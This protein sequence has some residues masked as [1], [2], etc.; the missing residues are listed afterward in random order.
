VGVQPG[1][2]L[3]PAVQRVRGDDDV[4][5]V[6]QGGQGGGERG[7]LVALGHRGLG[8]HQPAGVVID[9]EHL[10]LC[11][12]G[13]T[14][15]AQRLAVG[16]QHHSTLGGRA[17]GRVSLREG[18]GAAAEHPA[19]QRRLQRRRIQSAQQPAEGTGVR[20]VGAHAHLVFAGHGP[21]GDRRV[22]P[23]AGH[24][25]A[26]GQ[27]EDRL[28]AV[29][30]SPPLARIGHRGQRLQQADRLGGRQRPG[31][32]LGGGESTEQDGRGG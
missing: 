11:A 8:E 32:H 30:T 27:Q 28:Q 3:A 15:A 6:G 2:V 7:D 22:R 23:G 24:D 5:Q 13:G 10:G 25:R 20:R 14:G 21:V 19:G 18:G 9:A 4:V 16:G 17:T 12:R 26:Q 31:R 1:G 29:T